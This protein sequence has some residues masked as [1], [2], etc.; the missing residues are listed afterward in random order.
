MFQIR[1]LST[2]TTAQ[3][4]QLLDD[5][6]GTGRHGRTAYRVREGTT[7]IA[8]LSFAVKADDG[9]LIGSIQCWPVQL[10]G[11][12]GGTTP[13]VMVGPVAVDPALQGIGI[14]RALMAASIAA[15]GADAPL[16]LI[17]DPDYY[18]QFGFTAERTAQWRMPG[19]YEQHRILA[20]GRV[21]E[22]AGMVSPRT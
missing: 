16:M 20:I 1:P 8:A 3:V 4:E 11:D 6:F 22:G 12:D 13:M 5:A 17:G 15:A 10:D 14:G 21:P 2:A 9:R 7:A 19:P 18:R